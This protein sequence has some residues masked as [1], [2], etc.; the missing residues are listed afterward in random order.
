M[1]RLQFRAKSADEVRAVVGHCASL[2]GSRTDWRAVF[3][4]VLAGNEGDIRE[5]A[6]ELAATGGLTE[7]AEVA[8]VG[9]GR[10]SFRTPGGVDVELTEHAVYGEPAEGLRVTVVFNRDSLYLARKMLTAVCDE[11]GL[12]RV[13]WTDRESGPAGLVLADHLRYYVEN[14]AVECDRVAW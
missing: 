3:G 12:A 4:M 9:P 11:C 14:A 2:A 5:A 6:E 13:V 10:V 1:E 8:E 7:L